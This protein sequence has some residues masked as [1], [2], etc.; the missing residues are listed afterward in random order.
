SK[1]SNLSTSSKN[2]INNHEFD[3]D[4]PYEIYDPKVLRRKKYEKK[5]FYK[6]KIE[7]K[8]NFIGRGLCSQGINCNINY[9]NL[10]HPTPNHM[11]NSHLISKY[12]KEIHSKKCKRNF[13]LGTRRAMKKYNNDK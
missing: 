13:K 9:C 1:V 12:R 11:I 7:A 2:L 8:A 10:K 5:I 6:L 4:K 3:D